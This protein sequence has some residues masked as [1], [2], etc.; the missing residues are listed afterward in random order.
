MKKFLSAPF[1]LGVG[2]RIGSQ[3][4]AF[5]L[6]MIASRYLGLT[7][8]GTYALAWAAAVVANTFVFTG[9]Y[10]AVLR[11]DDADREMDQLFY[12]M[13]GVGLVGSTIIAGAGLLAP[14]AVG[15]ALLAI[16]PIPTLQ[17]LPAWNEA[18][19]V[20]SGRVRSASAYTLAAEASALGVALVGFRHGMGIGS[21]IAARYGAVLVAAV[22]TTALSPRLPRL[23]RVPGTARRSLRT[24]L[25]LW[26]TASVGMFSNYGADLMLGIFLNPAAVGAYRGGARIAMTASDVVVQ[27]L[28]MLTWARFSRLERNGELSRLGAAWHETISFSVALIWPVMASVA[29][30]SRDLVLTLFNETWL[31]AAGVVSILAIARSFQSFSVLLEPTMICSGR[32]GVQLRIRA[33]GAAILLVALLVLGRHGGEMAAIAQLL[34]GLCVALLALHA[35]LGQLG[36][37]PHA[38]LAAMRPGAGLTLACI[39]VIIATRELRADWPGPQGLGLTVALLAL[40]W[41][42][43]M[44]LFLRKGIL[45]LPA[46]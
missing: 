17:S 33:I 26:A 4:I 40:V 11:S 30:L 5:V 42:G 2:T 46:A 25:P 41:V 28:M 6:V 18:R 15:A 36:L 39:A 27:P 38:A 3:I 24:A 8:F 35:M 31:A 12:L 20:Q 43:I 13:L 22:L 10:Q 32:P 9:L 14:G 29:L 1:L 23:R 7:A 45:V 34:T 16:A 19:L 44:A 37:G 21:L